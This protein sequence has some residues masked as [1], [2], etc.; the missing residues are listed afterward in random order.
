MK[1]KITTISL[2]IAIASILFTLENMI[3]TP[4]PWFRLGFSNIITLLVL[5][6]WGI[7]ESLIVVTMRVFLGGLLSGKLFNPI[8]IISLS[9]SISSAIGMG[10]LILYCHQIFSIIGVSIIGAVIK[11]ITQLCTA[12]LLFIKN[13]SIF[14]L[15]PVFMIVS[16]ITG[17][18]IGIIT[19]IIDEKL[20][21]RP[22]NYA[23]SQ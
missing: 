12:Y 17:A 19:Y 22:G 16:L 5:K 9:G 21:I 2:L 15:I 1:N 14:S 11:N 8:F 3:P 7:K 20:K 6:W 18:I 4:L 23:K 10:L 13:I